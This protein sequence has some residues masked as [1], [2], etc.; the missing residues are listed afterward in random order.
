MTPLERLEQISMRIGT[1]PWWQIVIE[2]SA[3]WVVVYIAY[4]FIRGTRAASAVKGIILLALVGTL[5]I[6]IMGSHGTFQ[7]LGFL[8]DR[9]LAVLALAVVVIFAPELRRALTRLGEAQLFRKAIVPQTEAVDAIADACGYLSKAKFGGIIVVERQSSLRSFTDGATI[10]NAQVSA[11]LLKTI[12]F[13]STALHD[14]AV[15]VKGK[16][17]VAA[18]VQLPLAEPADMPD[19][20]LGSRHRAAVGIS[21][22]TDAV[23]VVVSEESGKISLAEAG[24]LTRGLSVEELRG[25]LVL[26]LNRGLVGKITRAAEEQ[27]A[28]TG[29]ATLDLGAEVGG[30]NGTGGGG[31]G[32]LADEREELESVR[33]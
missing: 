1:Y 14:L 27:E 11:E 7:R 17:I 29:D 30:G 20:S 19:A 24:K 26:K 32:R 18:G 16:L 28:R 3:I 10:L 8:Y 22:E 31:G 25:L 33:T 12:F 15:L 21:Q 5:A 13:P 4:R 23:V 6:R 9:L 2:L